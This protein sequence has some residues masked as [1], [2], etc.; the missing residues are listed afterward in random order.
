MSA[1][2]AFEAVIEDMAIRLITYRYSGQ[3]KDRI[4]CPRVWF[5]TINNI[6]AGWINQSAMR[7][8]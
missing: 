4:D 6:Y 1:W 7:H 5:A 2:E 8:T 3:A